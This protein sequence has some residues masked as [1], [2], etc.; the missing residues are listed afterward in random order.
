MADIKDDKND[1]KRSPVPVL[2]LDWQTS[3]GTNPE[4]RAL[5]CGGFDYVQLY[6]FLQGSVRYSMH[7]LCIL[8][9]LNETY[10]VNIVEFKDLRELVKMT[11][12]PVLLVPRGPGHSI[13]TPPGFK[14]HF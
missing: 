12:V 14:I 5:H 11:C 13:G 8:Y 10:L 2:E 9:T 7:I 1:I 3:V 4:Q 6:N